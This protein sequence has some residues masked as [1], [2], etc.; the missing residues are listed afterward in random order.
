MK[1][2]RLLSA[3]IALVLL[4]NLLPCV[5]TPVAHAQTS[6][7]E[8]GK[9]PYLKA[10]TPS[11]PSVPKADPFVQP[12][13]LD[14]DLAPS[15]DDIGAALSLTTLPYQYFQNTTQ[16]TVAADDPVIECGVGT[17][18]NTVWYRFVPRFDGAV[19]ADTFGSNYDT[20]LAVFTGT[21]GALALVTCDDDSGGGSQSQVAFYVQANRTYYIEVADYGNPGGGELVFTVKSLYESTSIASGLL[22]A[23]VATSPTNDWGNEGRFV[24][25]TTGGD[26]ATP[27]DNDKRM[28]YGYPSIIGSSYTTLR[29]MNGASVSD[30][31][32]GEDVAP[33]STSSPSGS[34]ILTV[35]QVG[36]VR[37]EQR[38]S[39]AASSASGQQDAIAIEYKVINNGSTPLQIGARIMLDTMIGDNDG[40]PLFAPGYGRIET[41]HDFYGSSIPDYWVA[42][43]SS[44]YD[45]AEMKA[46]GSL[47]GSQVTLPDRLVIGHW[48]SALC[49]GT[50]D[51][52]FGHPWDFT[53]NPNTSIT[54]DSAVA[55]YYNPALLYAGQSRTMRT[56]YGLVSSSS[57]VDLAPDVANFVEAGRQN[58]QSVRQNARD[59][60]EVG[61]FFLDKLGPDLA[62][63]LI[64]V[65][66]EAI[67]M[68]TAGASWSRVGRGLGRIGQPGYEAGVH[69]SWRGWT[70]GSEAAKHWYKP[71]Y[72]ALHSGRD[73]SNEILFKKMTDAGMEYY[74]TG[75]VEGPLKD[76]LID[77]LVPGLGNPY[78]QY[79]GG[80]AGVLA[81][82]YRSELQ[83]EQDELL[84][85]LAVQ[86]LT[87]QQI[88]AY[89]D[90]MQAR[91]DAN[92]RIIG[93]VTEHRNLLWQ[94]YQDRKASDANWLNI[95]GWT[96]AKWVIIGACTLAWDGPGFYVSSL[97][98]AGVGMALASVNTA[99]AF[100]EDQTMTDQARRFLTGR[101][102]DAFRDV[103]L[104]TVSAL[105]LVRAGDP[106][107]IADAQVSVNAMQSFGHYRLWPN[108]W[109]AEESSRVQL[110]I[111]NRTSF[112]TTVGTSAAYNHSRFFGGNERFLPEGEALDL[113]SYG[114]GTAV[115]QLKW[116]DG[117]GE[118]PNEG[119]V[120][121]ILALGRTDTGTYSLA[122]LS[123]TW[124]PSRVE[125]V[126]GGAAIAPQGFTP[127]EAQQAPTLAYPMASAVVP[128]AGTTKYDA[129]I[130]IT[131]PFDIMVQATV[132]Q[133]FPAGF[134]ILDSGGAQVTGNSLTWQANLQPGTTRSL[135]ALVNWSGTVGQTTV[136]P[137]PTLSF[138][139]PNTG[140][141]DQYVGTPSTVEAVWPLKATGIVAPIW[142]I[143]KMVS[144][145]ITLTNILPSQAVEG[146]LTTEIATMSGTLLWSDSR[147]VQVGAGRTEVVA[148]MLAVPRRMGFA[149][150]KS[151]LTVGSVQRQILLEP[152]DIRG[153][154]VYLPLITR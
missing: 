12:S 129:I 138:R 73:L 65:A 110:A 140:Q 105:N 92:N 120:F 116:P 47:R 91:Q 1:A 59:V 144:I 69:A 52:L 142:Q 31:R 121:D 40:A 45:P 46:R 119:S 15:N 143:G 25:G 106:P 150:V 95:W 88:S 3:L 57:G 74:G 10:P 33:V 84:A 107:Q 28:L 9:L 38:L 137:S 98:T 21:R 141:G 139:E 62:K 94:S 103:A 16:A 87:P 14:P 133:T 44:F 68:Y 49:P 51:G 41:E 42:W 58:I 114:S 53:T 56:L 102:S 100:T 60:A 7:P 78:Q 130:Q 83:R 131:N 4:S 61:D 55:L 64:D 39:L 90:D 18:S 17:N 96:L 113:G 50:G 136:V 54:C 77:V 109:W 86:P 35:W 149:S 118:S 2:K 67:D 72:D 154:P 5:P 123:P 70:E 132:V 79:L 117:I 99:R 82:G 32:L 104:N 124:N 43:E 85:R 71:L 24:I 23:N 128:V 122:A 75:I 37:V 112:E 127:E 145:P 26:P 19:S 81:D 135:R 134:T 27:A 13:Q 89:R 115:I 101:T 29:V 111:A 8:T 11:Q 36:G 108:L 48:N 153:I 63:G 147:Q 146:V 20:V 80:P 151:Q 93:Q 125:M 97:A 30:Y 22:R 76:W 126:T 34:M 66:F 148:L 152:V 6:G